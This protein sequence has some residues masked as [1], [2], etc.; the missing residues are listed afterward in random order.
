MIV[1]AL[2]GRRLH[3]VTPHFNPRGGV[4]KLLDY[5]EHAAAAGMRVAVH[6]DDF[7]D[8]GLPLFAVQRF[9]GI[10]DRLDF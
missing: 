7:A 4:I 3:I 8:P 6:S 1:D 2:A 5:G 10:A 9:A